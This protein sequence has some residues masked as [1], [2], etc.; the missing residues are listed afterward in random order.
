MLALVLCSCILYSPPSCLFL[1]LLHIVVAVIQLFFPLLVGSAPQ[2]TKCTPA[3]HR[4]SLSCRSTALQCRICACNAGTHLFFPLLVGSAS[5]AISF[6]SLEPSM[7]RT[8][9]GNVH[10]FSYITSCHITLRSGAWGSWAGVECLQVQELG[11][12]DDAHLCGKCAHVF[13]HH[14]RTCMG[15]VWTHGA[16]LC[17]H[18]GP[19]P[20]ALS[21]SSL[22]PSM[23]HAA[24]KLEFIPGAFKSEAWRVHGKQRSTD[25]SSPQGRAGL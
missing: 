21:C 2:H 15:H 22:G 1:S 5:S 9:A 11:A 8:C 25:E 18:V 12:V 3:R 20:S 17:A 24:F 6:R 13:I 23:M 16:V 4:C 19:A 7:M 10:T 14:V